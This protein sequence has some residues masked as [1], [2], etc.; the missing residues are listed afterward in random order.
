MGIEGVGEWEVEREGRVV[1]RQLEETGGHLMPLNRRGYGLISSGAASPL[2][3]AKVMVQEFFRRDW[4]V[5]RGTTPQTFA[6]SDPGLFWLRRQE[7]GRE[8]FAAQ[9]RLEVRQ[10]IEDDSGASCE[11]LVNEGES[12]L[13][14][15][16]KRGGIDPWQ[17]QAGERLRR[18][19]TLAQM[20]PRM[21]IDLS[22]PLVDGIRGPR[23]EAEMSEIVLA[24]KQRF[25]AAMRA[26][27]PVISDLLFDVC[28]HL[29]GL[30][31][32]ESTR[33]WP[34]RAARVVLTIGL[35]RLAAHYGLRTASGRTRSWRLEE[36]L[37]ATG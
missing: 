18:D 37:S 24:A 29:I 11:V 23:P 25:T 34:K 30:E 8:P 5:P 15:L 3:V 14:W 9:H 26:A 1:L 4:V 12:P 28:C 13:G 6:L 27:G 10:R 31:A 35:D 22:Q 20:T 16:R 7:A 33:S 17:Y 2:R 36:M 32:A 19:F 21:A